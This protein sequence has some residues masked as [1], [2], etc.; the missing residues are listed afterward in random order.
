M[1]IKPPFIIQNDVNRFKLLRDGK[2]IP[3]A[4]EPR[5]TGIIRAAGLDAPYH[6]SQFTI[7]EGTIVAERLPLSIHNDL[8]VIE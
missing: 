6:G 4:D 8:V 1:T 5:F 2:L 3:F 7:S